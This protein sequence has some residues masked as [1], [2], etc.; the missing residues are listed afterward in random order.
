MR[1]KCVECGAAH[2]LLDKSL[3]QRLKERGKTPKEILQD[4]VF[5]QP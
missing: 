3:L 1:R 2:A 4:A 5:E